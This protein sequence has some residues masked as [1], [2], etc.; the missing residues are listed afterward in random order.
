MAIK[1]GAENKR[2]VVIA[3]VLFAFLIYLAVSQLVGGPSTPPP[4]P[5]TPPVALKPVPAAPAMRTAGTAATGRAGTV[6]GGAIQG[7]A[8]RQIAGSGLDPALHL[9]RLALSESIEYAGNGRNIFSADSAPVNIPDAVKTARNDQPAAPVG[10][11]PYVAPTPPAIDMKY[12]G[13]AS[14]KDG[15]R[16][17]FLLRGDDIFEAAS[18]DIVNRRYK[19]VSVDIHSIQ[20]T[21]LSYNNTQTL[22]LITN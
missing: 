21:D 8:A 4:K 11:A 18:G 3:V 2:N 7:P 10:P 13:Y 22:P 1:L 14:G 5:V 6:S 12:F 9:E 15:K 17:A 16:S 20:I 19:V